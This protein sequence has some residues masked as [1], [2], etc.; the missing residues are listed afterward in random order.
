MNQLEFAQKIIEIVDM[1]LVYLDTITHNNKYA[2]YI[3]S[4]METEQGFNLLA[5]QQLKGMDEKENQMSAEIDNKLSE[6]FSQLT[7]HGDCKD[8]G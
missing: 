4:V 8:D 1:K 5:H 2:D 3:K 7:T 6:L